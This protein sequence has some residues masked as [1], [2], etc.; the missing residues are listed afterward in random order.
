[1]CLPRWQLGGGYW[2]SWQS[3][4]NICRLT[5]VPSTP[6]QLCLPTRKCYCVRDGRYRFIWYSVAC[7]SRQ[8]ARVSVLIT[9]SLLQLTT[10]TLTLWDSVLSTDNS[11]TEMTVI[12]VKYN[13]TGSTSFH[14]TL[15]NIL[16]GEKYKVWSC[17]WVSSI[18]WMFVEN[19]R[20][21]SNDTARPAF[22]TN[23]AGAT[24][25]ISSIAA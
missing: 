23:W 20:S 3:T 16:E 24:N 15:A 18:M 12:S 2:L 13:R 4:V 22:Q 17:T 6:S 11:K 21:R 5:N 10:T 9:Q 1:M 25:H 8:F 7:Q 14:L 19:T